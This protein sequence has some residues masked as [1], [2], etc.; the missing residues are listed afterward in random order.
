MNF[1]LINIHT[2]EEKEIEIN[3][4]EDLIKLSIR[5]DC[6]L[7]IDP[8]GEHTKFDFKKKYKKLNGTIELYNDYRE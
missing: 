4:L 2:A 7:I 1:L 3:T 6:P 5:E 8:D